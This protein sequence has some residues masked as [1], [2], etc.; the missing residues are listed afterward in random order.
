MR[1]RRPIFYLILAFLFTNLFLILVTNQPRG[2]ITNRPRD[3]I[4]NQPRDLIT[5]Q[6]RGLITNQPRGI[7]YNNKESN[8]KILTSNLI[9]LTHNKFHRFMEFKKSELQLQNN[10]ERFVEN[11]PFNSSSN[12]NTSN[13]TRIIKKETL[14]YPDF[15]V[16]EPKF[17]NS[18]NKLLFY[19]YQPNRERIGVPTK[20][21]L[22]G[23]IVTIRKGTFTM[24]H[25]CGYRS[26]VS[27]VLKARD[28]LPGRW[29]RSLVPM[30]VPDGGTFQHFLDGTLPKIIQALDYIQRPQVRLLMPRIRDSIIYEIM[31]KLNISRGKIVS[32]SG[33]VGA[34]YLVYT[35]VTPPIHPLLW[36][37]ARS[38][39]G[40]P[41]K[42][43]IPR[44]HANVVIITRKGC[45]N[46][47]RI[48]L[49]KDHLKTR[50]ENKYTQSSV[51]EF[52]GPLNLTES[53]SLF[54][55]A[56]VIIGVH[57]GGLYNINFCPSNTTVIEIIPT[58]PDGTVIA[59]AHQ[60]FWLQSILLDHDYWRI[61]TTPDNVKGDVNVN[62]TLVEN[63]IDETW[64]K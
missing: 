15:N 12:K 28:I 23:E 18:E 50:L 51:I 22:L 60:I 4:T 26:N 17:I 33:S 1:Y 38:F 52:Q 21:Q 61:P 24:P 10:L 64:K 5:N 63:I 58:R 48:L 47:G 40:V 2:L 32:Y 42:L 34:D 20:D 11:F 49:N 31:E 53:I 62:I 9:N 8:N 25:D 35:C 3:L 44:T 45:F 16:T 36:Q 56:S 46:C 19:K 30:I 27:H 59:A 13:I 43:V 54:G 39:L 55:S 14:V 29:F 7:I 6:P 37:K 41:D 57:G